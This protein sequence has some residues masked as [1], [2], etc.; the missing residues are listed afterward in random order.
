VTVPSVPA[1]SG[2]ALFVGDIGWDTTV[3]VDRMPEPDEKVHT[4]RFTEDVG[5]VV[6][7][8]AVACALA[9]VPARLACRLPEDLAGTAAAVA[10]A[11]RG[12][13]L[14]A[15]RGPGATCRALVL[16]DPS[17]EKRLI[18]VPGAS[19]YPSQ[20]AVA[21]LLLDAAWVHT[22][23]YDVRA[24]ADLIARCRAAGVPCSVDLEPATLPADLD[25]LGH[26]LRGCR[27]VFVNARASA[28][29]GPDRLHALG[30]PEVVEALGPAGARLTT[31]GGAVDVPAPA[32]LRPVLDTTGAGDALAGWYVAERVRGAT[33]SDALRTAVA[34]A[35][36][37]VGAIGAAASYPTR[38]DLLTRL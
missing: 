25:A 31:L 27:A 30:I 6:T 26:L 14:Q 38:H 23:L 8:A 13:A 15:E 2:S 36:F 10:L 24:G 32:P 22:A 20:A 7:N 21:G 11:A 1:R 12:V 16:L 29:V 18:L 33:P 5:G 3:V 19:M 34:A 37:S 9:G 17:G 4:D 35:S 28:V